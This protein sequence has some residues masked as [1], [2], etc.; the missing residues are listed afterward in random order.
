MS[1]IGGIAPIELMPVIAKSASEQPI[2]VIVV[3]SA[4][5]PDG[6]ISFIRFLVLEP[7]ARGSGGSGGVD[8]EAK[9]GAARMCVRYPRGALPPRI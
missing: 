6:P 7:R 2:P 3:I 9:C 4:E 8:V 5:A 1:V